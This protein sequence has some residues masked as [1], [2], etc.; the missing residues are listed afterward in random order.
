MIRDWGLEETPNVNPDH[1]LYHSY[2]FIL[3]RWGGGEWE[4]ISGRFVSFK[5]CV[6][7]PNGQPGSILR[8]EPCSPQM[9]ETKKEE[10][11]AEN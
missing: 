5:L 8:T 4:L 10:R 11:N 2:S 6:S 7:D 3:F 1:G 9:P